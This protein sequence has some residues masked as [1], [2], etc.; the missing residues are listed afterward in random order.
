[1]SV[2][3]DSTNP[4][5][6]IPDLAAL[7]VE[8]RRRSLGE[9][10]VDPDPIRQFTAWFNDALAAR[11]VEPNAMTLATCGSSGAPS[12]RIVLL[13]GVE[14]GG[15]TFF[16]NY[17]SSK[18]HDL[19]DN[20][21]AALVFWWPELERQV[22]IE[23]TASRTS[24]AESDAYFNLR[25]LESRIGAAASPQSEP[26]ASREVL[27]RA[28]DAVRTR[29]PDGDVPRPP[30]WGGYRLTPTRLEF[31]QGR[32]SR[33]HDRIEYVLTTP[34]GGWTRQRLAP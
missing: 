5:S 23:G 28:V 6:T 29:H 3:A 13:K 1:M 15:F 7:R 12:A 10:E 30:Q 32:P 20:P 33:L 18:A 22:R 34:G 27:E 11:A 21:R 19:E 17:H 4:D 25:P 24:D 31:W 9:D 16:T 26:I 8:Y 2:N 14:A